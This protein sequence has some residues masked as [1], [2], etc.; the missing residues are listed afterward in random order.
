MIVSIEIDLQ[1]QIV[2]MV[3]V[4]PLH[5]VRDDSEQESSGSVKGAVA[6]LQHAEQ[7]VDYETCTCVDL[8]RLR[9]HTTLE[10]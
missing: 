9:Q 3:L 7:G 2:Q 4:T 8:P 5:K 10:R 1:Q 6:I